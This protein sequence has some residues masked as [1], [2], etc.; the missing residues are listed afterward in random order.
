MKWRSVERRISGLHD[1]FYPGKPREIDDGR[2]AKL[3]NTT[4]LTKPAN[5]ATHWSVRSV[6]AQRAISPTSV[7][8]Y[9]K[10]FGLLPHCSE[11]FK[12]STDPFFIGQAARRGWPALEPARERPCASWKPVRGL[13]S[14]NSDDY[15]GP[16]TRVN[17]QLRRAMSATLSPS[18]A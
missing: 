7:H 3:I 10:L 1:E 4:L 5:G 12:L 2:V 14:R 8:R 6:A 16:V 15:S 9:F 18:E 11:T 17:A 13:H